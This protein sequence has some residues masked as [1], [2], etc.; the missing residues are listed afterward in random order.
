VTTPGAIGL[1]VAVKTADWPNTVGLTVE[2]TVF[3]VLI[4]L[5]AW[6]TMV[7]ESPLVKFP[8]PAYNTLML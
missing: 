1:M 7:S 4:G 3:V 5:T 6:V 2:T 8:S